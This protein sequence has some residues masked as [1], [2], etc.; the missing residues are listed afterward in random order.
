MRYYIGR[1]LMLSALISGMYALVL[2]YSDAVRPG[3]EMMIAAG[4]A[5]LFFIGWFI[6]GAKK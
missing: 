5:C 2:G 6:S 1:G 4:S 3:K